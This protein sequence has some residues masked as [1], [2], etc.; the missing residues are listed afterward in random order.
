MTHGVRDQA[1]RNIV[2]KR[3][4]L[5][6][7]IDNDDEL[8]QVRLMEPQC[9]DTRSAQ[10]KLLKSHLEGCAGLHGRSYPLQRSRKDGDAIARIFPCETTGV[11]NGI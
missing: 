2:V 9:I 6:E 10:P 7:P 5:I 4:G 11:A 1:F 3:S 8:R